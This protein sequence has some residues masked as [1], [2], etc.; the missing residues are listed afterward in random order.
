[1]TVAEGPLEGQEVDVVAVTGFKRDQRVVVR[2]KGDEVVW[3]WPWN[4]A[5]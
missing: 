2:T 4:L 5:G 1:V 3:L